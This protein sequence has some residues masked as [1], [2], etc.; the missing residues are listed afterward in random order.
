[1]P[2]SADI[3]CDSVELSRL[4]LA[5]AA[6]GGADPHALARDA[7]LPGWALSLDLAMIP[8]YRGARLWELVEH[9]LE[10]PQVG[11]TA[12]GRH[13]VG[14]LDLYDYLFTT[15]ATLR[16]GLRIHGDFFPLVSTNCR[17]QIEAETDR[18]TTYSYRHVLRGGRGEELWTQFSIAGF[19]ARAQA[20]TGRPLIPVHV[21]FAQPAPRTYHAFTETFGTSLIDFDAPVTTFTLRSRDLDA[22][23]P[24][25]DPVLARILARYATS[26][27][28]QP[29][30]TWYE[31]FR[32]RLAE[33]IEQGNPTLGVLA[34]R[35]AVSPRTLQRQLAGQ[36]TTWRAELDS[37]RQYLAW[38]AG[39]AGATDMTR[40]ARHL[41]YSDPRSIRRA[42]RRWDARTGLADHNPGRQER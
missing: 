30:A 10:D 37:A 7:G 17:L 25:A 1:M 20:A 33:A 34:R 11:L 40:L 3:A 13:Q 26:L 35:M 41:G 27:I 36:G 19:C 29:P 18:Y 31:Y 12:V 28:P 14:D 8:S 23:M 42:L 6:A 24:G 9:A 39:Q 2:A 32:Q 21:G 5:V 22:P 15:A 4:L 16:D 38:H